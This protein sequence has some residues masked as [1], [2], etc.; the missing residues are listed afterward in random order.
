MSDHSSLP[1]SLATLAR[2]DPRLNVEY[3][4][5]LESDDHAPVVLVG[6]VHDHP[7]SIHRV[8]RLVEAV[9]P[10]VVGLE[11]PQIATPLFEQYAR[12]SESGEDASAGGEMS[13]AIQTAGDARIVGLDMPDVASFA[14]LARRMW[15]ERVSSKTARAVFDDVWRLSRHALAVRLV[16]TGLPAV[17]F[18]GDVERT[19]SY[20]VSSDDTPAVQAE[21][22]LRHVRRS[23]ALLRSLEPPF[24]TR[25]VD[26][27]RERRIASRLAAL[28]GETDGPV[29]AV[30]GYQHLDAVET[31]LDTTVSRGK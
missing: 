4:R 30:L 29:V 28:R 2:D 11:L 14:S 15:T 13:A 7:A 31:I 3:V 8:R 6:V 1:Y 21:H 17:L 19:Q 24:A 26:D 16:A 10:S 9:D 25:L 12:L 18:D 20:D 22:E 27:V 23:A 5:L